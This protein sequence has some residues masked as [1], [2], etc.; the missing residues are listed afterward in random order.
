[1]NTKREIVNVFDGCPGGCPPPAVFTQTGTV[2]QM[3]GRGAEWPAANFDP[4]GMVALALRFSEM[5]GFATVRVPFCLTVEA[6]TLGA[7][8]MPGSRSSQPSVVGSPFRSPDGIGMPPENMIGRDEFVSSGRCASV[9]DAVD[10]L[11]REREDLFLT[12]GI[13]DPAGIASQLLGTENMI[14][15]YLMEPRETRAWVD[16]MV[17]YAVAYA[18]RLSESADNVL[19]IGSASMDIGS[20]EMYSDLTEGQLARTLSGISCFSTVHSCGSTL[21]VVDSLVNLGADGLSLEASHDPEAYL[22]RVSGRC[23][24]FGSVD[25]V[26]TLLSKGPSDVV[27]EARRY[28]DLGFDIVTPECGVPPMTPDDNL[29]ALSGYRMR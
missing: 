15:G 22:A 21:E 18:E 2:G 11:A 7:E 6:E 12:A 17:P 28:A 1:M 3:D 27:A 9:A 14:M 5:F 4:D 29:R 19:V 10:R 13:L 26:G 8:V 24:M 16:A 25:P 20:P 23:L